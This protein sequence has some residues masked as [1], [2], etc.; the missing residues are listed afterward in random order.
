VPIYFSKRLGK[1]AKQ[2][3]DY[4]GLSEGGFEISPGCNL[5]FQNIPSLDSNNPLSIKC[6]MKLGSY[7]LLKKSEFPTL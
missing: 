2:I 5:N 3:M 1:A 6:L 7:F 4:V